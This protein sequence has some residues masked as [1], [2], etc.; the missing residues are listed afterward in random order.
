MIV[1]NVFDAC[2]GVQSNVMHITIQDM[3]SAFLQV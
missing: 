3:T 1:P 2:H